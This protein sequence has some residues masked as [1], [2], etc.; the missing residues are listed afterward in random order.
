MSIDNDVPSVYSP[1]M[2]EKELINRGLAARK[3]P[4]KDSDRYKVR[5]A[6]ILKLFSEGLSYSQIGADSEVRLSKQ[7]VAHIIRDIRK[8]FE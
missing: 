3:I 1:P 8:G 2:N 5:K 6:R 7:R 4:L